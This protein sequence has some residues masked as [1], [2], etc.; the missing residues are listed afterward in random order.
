MKNR[1]LTAVLFLSLCI[2]AVP[3]L[4][5]PCTVGNGCLS[6]R[7][8]IL[9]PNGVQ[10]FGQSVQESREVPNAIYTIRVPDLIDPTMYGKPIV[11]LEPPAFTGISDIVGVVYLGGQYYLGF[12][13]DSDTGT[14]PV[15]FGSGHPTYMNET[16][17]RVDVTAFLSP[18]LRNAGYTAFF[19]SDVVE[20]PRVPEP[21]AAALVG[22]GLLLVAALRR[23]VKA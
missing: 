13:S 16:N 22:G 12:K 3:L 18:V 11:L 4:A 2:G 20:A 23:R 5:T 14:P 17:A 21:A 15:T 7:I 1:T 10:V 6:D 8:W 9:D 19:R